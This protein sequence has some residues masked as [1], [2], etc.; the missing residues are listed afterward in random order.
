LRTK[1]K[2]FELLVDLSKIFFINRS[3][4]CGD[5]A[6]DDREYAALASVHEGSFEKLG[7]NEGPFQ[8]GHF[9]HGFDCNTDLPESAVFHV[10]T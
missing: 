3:Y 5:F 9:F 2:S 10:S 8:A 1:E 7:G 4:F 6:I